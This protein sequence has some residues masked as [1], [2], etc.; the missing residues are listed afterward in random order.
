MQHVPPAL[1][2]DHTHNH[3]PMVVEEDNHREPNAKCG[4]HSLHQVLVEP[5]HSHI[6]PAQNGNCGEH[7]SPES[8]HIHLALN[9]SYGKHESP[10]VAAAAVVRNHS[11]K[12]EGKVGPEADIHLRRHGGDGGDDGEIPSEKR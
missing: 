4:K 3:P 10:E 6:H 5:E 7:L 8:T 9:G 12:E 11:T 2:K 1:K